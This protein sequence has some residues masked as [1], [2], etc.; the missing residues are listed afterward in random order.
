MSFY[1]ILHISQKDIKQAGAELY[2]AQMKPG[3]A[4]P[5]IISLLYF[6]NK[7]RSSSSCLKIEVVFH[8]PKKL[9]SS[10]ICLKK[11]GRLPCV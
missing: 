8:L 2:Q 9:R 7:L 5:K 3:L 4:I 1:V 10:S 11:L 6:P